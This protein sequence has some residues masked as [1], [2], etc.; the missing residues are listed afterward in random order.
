MASVRN[1]R[2]TNS[3]GNVLVKVSCIIFVN[4]LCKLQ[5][6][7]DF[8]QLCVEGSPNTDFIREKHLRKKLHSVEFVDAL[9]PVYK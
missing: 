3:I 6:H 4:F 1:L 2:G 9:F 8:Y 7:N 5:S